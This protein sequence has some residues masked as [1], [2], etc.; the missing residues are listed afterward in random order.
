MIYYVFFFIFIFES[1][2]FVFFEQ[3]LNKKYNNLIFQQNLKKKFGRFFLFITGVELILLY[4]LRELPYFDTVHDLGRYAEIY[5]A[6]SRG[7]DYSYLEPG[8]TLYLKLCSYIN[9][10]SEIFVLLIFSIP[11]IFFTFGFIYKYSKNIYLSV[12]IYYGFMFYFFLFNGVRQ[13]MSMAIGLPAF[14][15]LNEKKWIKA[16]FFILLA[17]SFHHSAII[18]LVLFVLQR[19]HIKIDFRYFAIILLFSLVMIG[20]GRVLASLVA[21]VLASSYIAYLEDATEGNWANPVIYLTLVGIICFFNGGKERGKEYLLINSV[22][23]GTLIYFM[24]TQ[25]QI[26]NRMAYYF[27]LPIICVLPN[28]I[29]EL[30][31]YRI[32]F[33]AT[34]GCYLAI[35]VYGVLLVFNNAH[36]ILPYEWAL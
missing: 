5:S 36:G 8:F 29:N 32:R 4:S 35:T 15:F 25:A 1:F 20:I 33:F 13:C 27:T 14:Y 3:I 24:S 31:D 22:V 11:V 23:F 21:S 17:T 28:I 18:L 2:W 9:I 10:D 34:F 19:I 26:L 30:E 7:A 12:Y 6:I 16:L